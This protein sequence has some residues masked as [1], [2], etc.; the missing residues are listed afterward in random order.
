MV[1]AD[2]LLIYYKPQ[3]AQSSWVL[4]D[5]RGSFI[6]KLEHGH[7]SDITAIAKGKCA[8]VL[9]DSACINIENVNIP[10]HNKQRQAQAVPF[11]LEEQLATDIDDMHFAVGK[12]NSN[13]EIPVVSINKS[14]LDATLEQFSEAEIFVDTLSADVLALPFTENSWS[15]LVDEDGAIIKTDHSNGYYCD[16]DNLPAILS[17]LFNTSSKPDSI[18]YFHKDDDHHAAD[19]IANIDTAI[20]INTYDSHPVEIF[21]KN[22][23]DAQQLNILQG[24]YAPKRKS[25]LA[26]KPWKSVAALFIAWLFVQLIS[27]NIESN[28]LEEK[29]QL[30]TSQIEKEFKR[31]NPAARKFNNMRKRMERQL[32][33]LKNGGS[34]SN[35]LF[36]QI[37]S[38]AAPAFD[39]NKTVNIRGIVFRS[40]YVDMDLQAD[41]L[42]SLEKVKALLNA[43]KKLKVVMSTSVEKNKT[44][45]RLRLE[46]QG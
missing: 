43:N 30:L 14:F 41:S 2:T 35:P 27:A 23:S 33:Q 26:F 28:Q 36:L 9:I 10:G 37:L 42:Q 22:I 40:Q 46:A 4:I 20:S 31:A 29:N 44:R 7:L 18:I 11:A 19:L 16:R 38:D 24:D 13:H 15:I 3:S 32:K 6:S 1:M 12:I 45:G 25:N 21:S 34:D 17:S 5:D 39:K 8:T